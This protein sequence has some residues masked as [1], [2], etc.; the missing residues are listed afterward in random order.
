MDWHEYVTG[1]LIGDRLA[2]LRA[3]AALER[4]LGEHLPPRP[5]LRESVGGALI[6]LGS[7]LAGTDVEECLKTS[8]RRAT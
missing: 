4:R 5:P 2:E 7:W 6:R 8:Y 1:E 3:Q